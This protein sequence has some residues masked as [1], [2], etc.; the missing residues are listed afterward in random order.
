MNRIKDKSVRFRTFI[1]AEINIIIIGLLSFSFIFMT[2]N[3]FLKIWLGNGYD[4]MIY[5]YHRIFLLINFLILPT[6]PI[7][8]YLVTLDNTSIQAKMAFYTM[9]LSTILILILFNFFSVYG[10]IFSK[11]S[12]VFVTVIA[13]I[14]ISKIQNK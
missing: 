13:L 3:F 5:D 8:Y 2:S 1:R 4:P 9:I 14:H 12:M 7:Y 6:I 11:L 10:I